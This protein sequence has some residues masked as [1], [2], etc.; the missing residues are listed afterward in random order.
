VD[1]DKALGPLVPRIISALAPFVSTV[2]EDALGLVLEGLS[3]VLEVD[4]GNWLTPDQVATVVQMLL[5][6]FE[7]NINGMLSNTNLCG[8]HA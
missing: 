1:D 8:R 3:A 6:T 7:N 5:V 4:E 2:T